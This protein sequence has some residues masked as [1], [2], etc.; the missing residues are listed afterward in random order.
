MKLGGNKISRILT[1]FWNLFSFLEKK[2]GM[3]KIFICSC[4][5]M[6]AVFL[7]TA[8]ILLNPLDFGNKMGEGTANYV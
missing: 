7:N 4:Q 1:D 8:L 3:S 2:N 5:I 6:A